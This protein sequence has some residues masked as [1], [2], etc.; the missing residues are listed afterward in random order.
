MLER[1]AGLAGRLWGRVTNEPAVLLAVVLVALRA[2]GA[3]VDA[4]AATA[5]AETIEGNVDALMGLIAVRQTVDGPRTRQAKHREQAQDRQAVDE[6]VHP[7]LD[8]AEDSH[9]D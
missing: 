1:L 9:A 8:T 5:A 2:M 6:L 3:D 7:R 4:D